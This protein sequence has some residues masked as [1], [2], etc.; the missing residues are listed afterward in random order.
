ME[1]FTK[2]TRHRDYDDAELTVRKFICTQVPTFLDYRHVFPFVSD[3]LNSIEFRA[4]NVLHNY[5][6]L[7][8]LPP[9]VLSELLGCVACPKNVPVLSDFVDKVKP[10]EGKEVLTFFLHGQRKKNLHEHIDALTSDEAERKRLYTEIQRY[11]IPDHLDRKEMTKAIGS[12]IRDMPIGLPGQEA[13]VEMIEK[14]TKDKDYDVE[15][16]VRLSK[17][18]PKPPVND[19]DHWEN[20]VLKAF[21]VEAGLST[22][23]SAEKTMKQ[24]IA[25]MSPTYVP[26]ADI[27]GKFQAEIPK[28]TLDV[29][30]EYVDHMSNEAVDKVVSTQQAKDLYVGLIV[31]PLTARDLVKA[32]IL[33]NHPTQGKFVQVSKHYVRPE[34]ID[35]AI[36]DAIVDP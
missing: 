28:T 7:K 15:E 21:K 22:R 5:A 13:A 26:S 24:M 14:K 3:D 8:H 33:V 2:E 10:P 16:E 18:D 32:V 36:L 19:E 25:G 31:K 4:P 20:P 12:F 9:Q 35:H 1:A 27:L 6:T 34:G 30:I 23:F 17:T 29:P 11:A